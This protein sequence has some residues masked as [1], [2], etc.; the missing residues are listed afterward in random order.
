MAWQ[1]AHVAGIKIFEYQRHRTK[2][3]A[4]ESKSLCIQFPNDKEQHWTAWANRMTDEEPGVVGGKR[5]NLTC[6]NS[7]RRYPHHRRT[8]GE[9]CLDALFASALPPRSPPTRSRGPRSD[10]RHCLRLRRSETR[11]RVGPAAPAKQG[12]TTPP[13]SS[14]DLSTASVR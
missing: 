14:R 12:F 13:D 10:L 2:R 8:F 3:G 6:G 7:G 1:E 11:A 5:S 9:A 4:S